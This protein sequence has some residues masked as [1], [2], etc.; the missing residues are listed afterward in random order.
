VFLHG[1]KDCP[2]ED[3]ELDN[4]DVE[5]DKW[6]SY[7]GGFYDTRPGIHGGVYEHKTAG[8]FI[9][10]ASGVDLRDMKI[11]WGKT[12]PDYFGSAIE[13]HDVIG[14]EL[15]DFRGEAAHPGK[16]MDRIIE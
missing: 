8:I 5:I 1:W 13:A 6:T 12:L 10:H 14:L 7:P 3:I 4:V 9:K 11:S 15:Q 2:I 16:D